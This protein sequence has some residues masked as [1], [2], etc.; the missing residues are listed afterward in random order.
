MQFNR[1]VLRNVLLVALMFNCQGI[2][3]HAFASDP[4]IVD[5]T[6]TTIN[7]NARD[8]TMQVDTETDDTITTSLVCP[9][10]QY[11]QK[12]G[13]YRV[14]FNWLKSAQLPTTTSYNSASRTAY[15]TTKN[16]Y[17]SNDTLDLF[18][19]MRT[20]FGHNGSIAIVY[21]N[22][23]SPATT[24]SYDAERKLILDNLCSTTWTCAACP[25]GAMVPESTVDLDSTGKAV[26]WDF[27]TIADCYMT[28]FEDSTGFYFYVPDTVGDDFSN[29]T[30]PVVNC[31]YTNTNP[32]AFDILNGD[33]IGRFIPNV[34][35][36]TSRETTVFIPS[37]ST[38]MRRE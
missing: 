30:A 17:I 18:E 4:I 16:Y 2:G 35:A 37:T 34:N 21:D 33:A 1:D 14:G 28:E 9:N 36:S 5:Q 29:L 38:T 31:Y 20:F 10:G 32:E 8:E 11:V 25:N 24:S 3:N 7:E 13:N 23:G 27:F 12:C 26:S 15:T 19:Q 6:Q 22:N